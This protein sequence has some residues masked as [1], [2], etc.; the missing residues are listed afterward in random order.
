VNRWIVDSD[1]IVG[2]NPPAGY[3]R[4]TYGPAPQHF[5]DIRIPAGKP[6]GAIMQIHGGFWRNA[7]DL[8]HGVHFCAALTESGYATFNVEY[9]RVGDDGGGW[10]GTLDD[11]RSAYA[12]VRQQ[13]ANDL[14]VIGH[15]AGGQLAVALAAHEPTLKRVISLAGV[16]DL[17][18]AFDLHLSNNAVVE[19]LGGTP[20]SAP[21]HYLQA[22]PTGLH[23][24][25][26]QLI[27]TGD[28]DEV[29]PPEFSRAYVRKKLGQGERVELREIANASHF[30]LIDPR[31]PSFASVLEAIKKIS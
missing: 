10:P 16:L 14:I 30:D 5:I 6:V 11:L 13:Y 28:A 7:H 18:Q 12:Y 21:E 31:S 17:Y 1:S 9:R 4:V 24:T 26:H 22:S 19:F 23:V 20:H 2:L 27:I 8:A 3:E 15:S 25:A 29:V